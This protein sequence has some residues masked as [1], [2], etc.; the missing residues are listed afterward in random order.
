M[1]RRGQKIRITESNARRHTH[2]AKGDVG[3]LDNMFLFPKDRFIL[4]NMFLCS[5]G[6]S[7]DRSERKNFILDLGMPK[8]VTI[9]INRTG[10]NKLFFM[11][12]PSINLNPTFILPRKTRTHEIIQAFPQLIGTYGVW[13]GY[14]SADNKR[15]RHKD[16][17]FRIPCGNISKC[18]E[19]KSRLMVGNKEFQSWIKS[20]LAEL[21]PLLRMF[22]DFYPSNGGVLGKRVL[23]T[24]DCISYI[25]NS[26][27][28]YDDIH[29]LRLVENKLLKMTAAD[30]SLLISHIMKMRNLSYIAYGQMMKNRINTL[31]PKGPKLQQLKDILTDG[32]ANRV[33]DPDFVHGNVTKMTTSIFIV[34][35]IYRALMTHRDTYTM[36]QQLREYLP[37]SW[38]LKQMA[39]DAD[40]IKSIADSNSAALYCIFDIMKPTSTTGSGDTTVNNAFS[41]IEPTLVTGRSDRLHNLDMIN[42]PEWRGSVGAN[43]NVTERLRNVYTRHVK[44]K[45]VNETEED[46]PICNDGCDDEVEECEDF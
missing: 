13:T 17:T 14:T 26:E 39:H 45:V 21:I 1:F 31:M 9:K 37:Y 4:V 8:P 44:A 5:Y 16:T 18:N 10:V 12:K 34:K 29:Y 33:I 46:E 35:C 19:T 27:K 2:P 23:H 15:D 41:L 36:L 20:I 6:D 42:M 3:Y 28:Q 24:W 11:S 7:D 43:N 38:D 25:F 40:E 30:R 22:T 32:L